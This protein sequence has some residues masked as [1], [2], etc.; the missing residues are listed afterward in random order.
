[1][2]RSTLPSGSRTTTNCDQRDL[3]HRDSGGFGEH[4][5]QNRVVID[6][7]NSPLIWSF[8]PRRSRTLRRHGDRATLQPRARWT[9][10]RG[11]HD[12]LRRQDKLSMLQ[13]DPHAVDS[14][15]ETLT[16]RPADLPIVILVPVEAG[17]P[18]GDEVNYRRRGEERSAGL[19]VVRGVRGVDLGECHKAILSRTTRASMRGP[20]QDGPVPPLPTS[21]RAVARGHSTSSPET[22]FS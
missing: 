5:P 1:M 10:A 3:P 20:A 6:A 9:A 7:V 2:C 12:G 18:V 13:P 21:R 17:L 15:A 4:L 19:A 14:S 22:S 8:R 16:G 11:G